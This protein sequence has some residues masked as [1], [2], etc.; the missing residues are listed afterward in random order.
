MTNEHLVVTDGFT[1]NP[2]DLSWRQFEVFG[3]VRVHPRT[4]SSEVSTRCADASIIIT[5]K[6]VIGAD[7][8]R[9]A[10]RL[11]LVAVTATG[12][13]VV[14]TEAARKTKIPVC[15]VPGYGTDSVAQHTF[16]L[17]LELANRVG[18]NSESVARG[19]WS[20]HQDWCYSTHPI[21]ELSGK[22]LGIVGLGKI[23]MKVAQIGLAFGM[24]VIFFN[25]GKTS[26]I[27]EAVELNELFRRADIVSLHC[28]L[29]Y[30]NKGF[31]NTALLQLM[32]PSALLINTSRGLLVN[33]QDLA[34]ALDHN[35]IAGAALDVLSEEPPG[36]NP[37][38]SRPN[39]IITPHNAWLS[40]E[41]RERIMK[42]T[43]EN[44][45][46]FLTGSPTNIVN[47]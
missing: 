37:L 46:A 30:E 18:A 41:A 36:I 44:I 12:Y 23:G 17:I 26:D 2:G 31:I 32:K 1:L 15:N 10:T 27:G 29:T 25:K 28:P 20:R 22:T 8:I 45:N 5:N 38:I 4:S 11:K 42:A 24:K 33:E 40:Y 21:I 16:A 3:E 43:F 6:T 9:A 39:C 35:R 13:N 34:L 7:V 47:P 19:E 14:D